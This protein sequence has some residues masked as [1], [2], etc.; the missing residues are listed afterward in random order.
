MGNM[1]TKLKNM[2]ISDVATTLSSG[3]SSTGW[4]N[5]ETSCSNSP[6]FHVKS[7]NDVTVYAQ[8]YG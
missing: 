1:F 8:L 3:C 7:N 4:C 6:Y 5:P 2:L